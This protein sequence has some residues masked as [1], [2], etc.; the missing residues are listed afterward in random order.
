M[1][2]AQRLSRRL[3]G[4]AAALG[5][6]SAALLAGGRLLPGLALAAARTKDADA[7][8]GAGDAGPKQGSCEAAALEGMQVFRAASAAWNKGELVLDLGKSSHRAVRR[9]LAA[10]DAEADDPSQCVRQR[11]ALVFAVKQETRLAFNV[12]RKFLEEDATA[13]LKERLLSAMR[14]RDEPLRVQEKMD[15][16]QAAI[17]NFRRDLD[18]LLPPDADVDTDELEQELA[19]AEGRLGELQFTI[20]DSVG[21]RGVQVQWAQRRHKRLTNERAHG[22]SVS[23]DPALRLMVRPEGMG[24]IQIFG[25]GPVGPPNSP[26]QVHVGVMNDA[27]MSDTYR[28]HPV[29][30]MFSLQPA[31]RVNLNV[32]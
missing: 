6:V 10:F 32:R 25:S 1:A 30:P 2:P 24:N 4:A 21:G 9:A 31:A 19:A 13:D 29:P 26:A 5:C 7:G 12:Q 18:R 11:S 3:R 27:S 17:R 15:M 16:L 14:R 22:L 23:L 8:R 20:E 28:E